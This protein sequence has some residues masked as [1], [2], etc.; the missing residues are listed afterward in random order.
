LQGLLLV[1]LGDSGRYD[2]AGLLVLGLN[3]LRQ[4]LI[5]IR[6]LFHVLL[7]LHH[8]AELHGKYVLDLPLFVIDYHFDVFLDFFV[9]QLLLLILL[10]S[11]QDVLLNLVKYHVLLKHSLLNL[12]DHEVY[13]LREFLSLNFVYFC[14]RFFEINQLADL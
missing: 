5:E 2:A 11:L 13:F 14:C 12:L 9:V 1:L 7:L 10:A 4:N 6:C 8:F 3:I